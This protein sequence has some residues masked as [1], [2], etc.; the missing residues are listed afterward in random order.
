M[1]G[2]V[3]AFL[4]VIAL[5]C[6]AE[7]LYGPG[8]DYLDSA[9]REQVQALEAEVAQGMPTTM[10]N[11]DARVDVLWPWANVLAEQGVHLPVELPRIVAQSRQIDVRRQYA[12]VVLPAINHYVR[13][14]QIK[15]E[16]PS[17]IGTVTA[18]ASGPWHV[19]SYVTFEQTYTVGDM[20]MKPG[21]GVLVA[22]ELVAR[23]ASYQRDD[24]S[25]MNYISIR[26]S[27]PDAEW[28]EGTEQVLGMHGNIF[29]AV[30][31]PSY[32]LKGATLRKGD[33]ITI[34]YGD[35]SGGSPG[36]QLQT[37]EVDGA[38][39]P[40]Y[41]DLEGAGNFM[42]PKWPT[43]RITGGEAARVA[44]FAPSVVRPDEPLTLA[45][46]TE[47]RY[48]NRATSGVPS[49]Q[50][51]LNGEFV[52]KA[53]KST[54]GV[55]VLDL[56]PLKEP[57]VYRFD[58]VA[59]DGSIRG[60][61]NPVWAQWDPPYRVYWGDTHAHTNFAEA[62]GN[63]E[64]FYRYARED[65]RL[66]FVALS[67][68]DIWMDDREWD[69]MAAAVKAHHD[70]RRFLTFLAYEWTAIVELG[71]HHNVYFRTPENRERIPIQHTD[72]LW[73]LYE[74]LDRRYDGRDV[75]IIPHAHIPGDW[76]LSHPVLEPL[77]EMVSMHG[78]FE[79]FANNYL[80]NGH[81]VGFVGASDDH[82]GRPGYSGGF[83]TGPLQQFG[84]LAAV[85][86]DELTTDAVFDAMKQRQAYATSGQRTLLDFRLNGQMM[87]RRLPYSADRK[88]EGRV[89]GTSP[90]DTIDVVKNGETVSTT[91]YLTRT[92]Q[93]EGWLQVAFYSES[94]D[95][96]RDAP[97]GHRIW[98]GTMDV[99]NAKIEA[100][101]P[102]GVANY[103]AE[104][105]R[106]DED[107]PN[108]VRFRLT[109][110]GVE[111]RV[112]L[113]LSG[114]SAETRLR[115]QTES[116]AEEG[117]TFPRFYVPARAYPPVQVSFNFAG[118]EDGEATQDVPTGRYTDAV[119]LHWIDP[120]GPLDQEFS[121]VDPD[122]PVDGDYY[123]L[124]V[125]QLDGRM[126]WS[127]PW[128]VGGIP[129]R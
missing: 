87:G 48:Y 85:L 49:Y 5:P 2:P 14:L 97:R 96:I 64:N 60:R 121:Y 103:E 73:A 99:E 53:P 74:G 83:L 125:T 98:L 119:R 40:L 126:A 15:E 88:I 76:H 90:I 26:C 52:T 51:L 27:N 16:T 129:V 124:R 32:V 89:M 45:V 61:S 28:E 17:A 65:A 117:V 7:P 118:L 33:T 94:T 75:M 104:W 50:V 78:T 19:R 58:I 20:P 36:L 70:E 108:R 62:Q 107:N 18:S 34:T 82:S 41:V 1:P 25:A 68:H 44:A 47:D 10:M 93:P 112:L 35:T 11:L 9:L 106:R 67:E 59:E 63:I 116:T 54:D 57:G 84:G 23:L 120:N 100:V 79:W 21:G 109:T 110:R 13:E 8:H 66:D 123:Y 71:G 111:D 43:F 102:V 42:S 4:L 6:A 12:F 46:R 72:G 95:L 77:V 3:V 115:I 128:W 56:P 29:G 55:T 31:M 122:D 92:M 81:T 30:G 37:T 38:M 113:K 69:A 24:P 105:V 114:V 39:F 80:R 127:S 86:A 101:D 91:H 22:W